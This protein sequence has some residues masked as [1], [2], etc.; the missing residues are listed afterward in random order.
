MANFKRIETEYRYCYRMHEYHGIAS[1][2]LS[3]KTNLA[4]L[5]LIME[6]RFV[7]SQEQNHVINLEG[8]KMIN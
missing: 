8:Q 5:N 3:E 7:S 2:L 6:T 1:I 4:A